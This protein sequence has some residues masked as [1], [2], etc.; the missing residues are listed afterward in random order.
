MSE[1]GDGDVIHGVKIDKAELHKKSVMIA[2]PMFG[3]SCSGL[4]TGSLLKLAY[5]FQSWD[6]PFSCEYLLGDAL[7]TRAR[8]RLVVD[9]LNSEHTHLLF[10]DA[11][12][13]FEAGNILVMLAH[14]K[15]MIAAPYPLKRINWKKVKNAAREGYEADELQKIGSS[16][17]VLNYQTMNFDLNY[18][19]SVPE[20]GT[21]CLLISKTVF[22]DM[23]NFYGVGQLGCKPMLDEPS[24]RGY[25]WEFFSCGKDSSEYY[26]P[27]DYTFCKK[28]RTMGGE[29]WLCPWMTLTHVGAMNFVG[30]MKYAFTEGSKFNSIEKEKQN[31][32]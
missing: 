30:N 14:K 15:E 6:I 7:I 24:W 31:V 10:L 13:G 5:A 19:I 25:G 18:A 21:G 4:Y 1:M 22:E 17:F 26:Q 12:I 28:W 27:E 9:F 2:T 29:I 8:N 16:D 23:A 3:G 20:V 32:G 11:D